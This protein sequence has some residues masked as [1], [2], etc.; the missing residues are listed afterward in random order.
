MVVVCR[1]TLEKTSCADFFG[2]IRY[3]KIQLAHLGLSVRGEVA[4][5]TNN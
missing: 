3:S 4:K 5:H 2:T 1:A